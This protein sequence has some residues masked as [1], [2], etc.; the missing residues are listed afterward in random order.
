M[1]K[2][3]DTYC[4]IEDHKTWSR[5]SFLQALGM[6]GAGSMALGSTNLAFANDSQLSKA[7]SEVDNDR[8]LLIIKLFGG[9]DTLNMVVPLEQYDLY[10]NARPTI[11]HNQ[12][13]LWNLNNS[14][15]MP[16]FMNHLE[17]MWG[18][19]KMKI[20]NSVGYENSSQ[21]H[22]KGT[23]IWES[24]DT[25]GTSE[26]GWMGKHFENQYEDYLI[27]P[28]ES[29]TAI[30]IGSLKNMTFDGNEAKYSFSVATINRL[31]SIAS[32]GI[33]YKLDETENSSSCQ[34]DKQ[35]KFLRSMAN[36]T[37]T[38]A[39]VIYDAYNS[40][41]DYTEGDGYD[42]ENNFSKSLNVISR[43]IKGNLGTKVYMITLKGFDTHSEQKET[44][45][46]LLTTLSKEIAYFYKDLTQAGWGDKV[47]S[48][49]IS[50]FSRRVH[51]N[52]SQGTDHGTAGAVMLFGEALNGSDIVGKHASLKEEDLINKNRDM[53]FH[54]DFRSVY[55][56]VLKEWM[57]V[58][59][60][61]V[62]QS[63]L[64]GDFDSLDL[65]FE[66]DNPT[67]NINNTSF[68]NSSFESD[69]YIENNKTVINI[70]NN[71]TQHIHISL[72]S[73][74]GRK[75][76]T[77]ANQLMTAGRHTID[78]NSNSNTDLVTGYYIY[79]IQSNRGNISKKLYIR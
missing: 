64:N 2:K 65:G 11:K 61:F 58:D 25:S 16:N 20:I 74:S 38:Y 54:T 53:Q 76:E 34:Y 50:E 30:Q 43:L 35:V 67:L 19:G 31:A 22:F 5:R 6:A 69:F 49:G 27:N 52:G 63:I 3:K 47:L 24:A 56:T 32:T 57:C 23:D 42:Q 12:S 44:H 71:Y 17:G 13:E 39:D 26:E 7:L 51:E 55:A 18:E 29:P 72:Y 4:N 1:K 40:S 79:Q 8:I 41:T 14:F 28:P 10:A 75:I 59:P 45:Q 48:M 60:N 33:N 46:E 37:Y 9:N 66:C 77:L 62:D 70:K 78:V 15:A 21:S 36:N 73:L 68:Q